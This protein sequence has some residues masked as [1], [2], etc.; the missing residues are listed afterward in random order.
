MS[1]ARRHPVVLL[2]HM[3]QPQYRDP[4]TGEYILP[5][6][7]LHAIKDYVDMAAHLEANPAA[8]AVVNFTPVLLEQL[9]DLAERVA[10]HLHDGRRLPDPMLTMLAEEPLPTDAGQR[11]QLLQGCLRAHRQHLIGR[12]PHYAELAGL[13]DTLATPDR[14]TFASDQ[15]L[16]DLA[17]WFHIAW[18]GETVKRGDLRVAALLE[19][20]RDFTA[21][22][23]HT[24]LEL[25]S[26]LLNGVLPR[27]RALY[28]QGRIELSTSPYAH[29]LMPLLVDF[30]S[31]REAMPGVA[32]PR[33]GEYPGGAERA[34]WHL[35]AGVE[36]FEEVFGARPAGCWPSEGAI[37]AK[38]LE[39][40]E[41][42]GYR[43]TASGGN[44]LRGC[45]NGLPDAVRNEPSSGELGRAWQ[46]PGQRLQCFF[47]NDEL[48]D[49][50]GF[51]FATW[52][53]DDAVGHLVGELERVARENRGQDGRVTLIALDGENAW[54]HYPFN[55]YYFLN[56]LYAALADH[57]EL[58]LTTLSKLLDR[59]DE[60]APLPRVIAG[61][62]VYG[63]LGTWIGERD[64]NAAWDLLV[65]AKRA[66]D[67][68]LAQPGLAAAP[69]ARIERHL[70]LC[71]GS[72]WFW[73][74]G[75]YNPAES[76]REFDSLFRHRLMR[77]Y[78]AL[79]QPVPPGLAQPLSSGHG[80]PAMGGTM[81]RAGQPASQP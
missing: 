24:M 62:W 6:V 28:E 79:G 20:G 75:E 11:L 42:C 7:Y 46:V 15:Y 64:K 2:W 41:S 45:L 25:I 54:E 32:L 44:V 56:G 3:H 52:H 34:L 9:E 51:T 69:R 13:A 17:M 21:Q 35:R 5:W 10:A 27:F 49:L 53:G 47:R 58:E 81:R 38:T 77:L 4:L 26:E 30:G 61:S 74:L 19:R 73:W 8:R 12:Y 65:E 16:R 57:A 63:T 43:W 39:L 1:A 48:S 59:G 33:A 50:I 18:L 36:V 68:V 37:S 78:D 66:A 31:A 29:P 23:R 14:V 80:Q 72:D 71:E 67:S 76:V 55:G 22:Q 70:A 60:P 40:I